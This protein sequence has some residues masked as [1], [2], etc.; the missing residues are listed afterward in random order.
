MTT[1]QRRF[2]RHKAT[3]SYSLRPVLIE[4]HDATGPATEFV[5][6]VVAALGLDLAE[7]SEAEDTNTV[8]YVQVCGSTLYADDKQWNYPEQQAT[9]EYWLVSQC[10]PRVA[11]NTVW[12]TVQTS[13]DHYPLLAAAMAY[14]TTGI[15]ASG[16]LLLDAD[17]SGALTDTILDATDN[18]VEV[19][20]FDLALPSPH[21]YLLNAP[22]WEDVTLL[23]Q[24]HGANP[25]NSVLLDDTVAAARHHFHTVVINCGADLFMAQRLAADGAQV[26]HVDDFSRPLYVQFEPYKKIDYASHRI[27]EYGTRR[28]F[29][30]IYTNTRRRK[31]MRRWMARGDG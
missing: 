4:T 26:V 25:L 1:T 11:H 5:Y 28:D 29:Q 17:A 16:T 31:G 30:F 19:L 3:A 23:L 8:V 2:R 27:P 20:D 9:F 12:A 7:P 24:R 14:A 6:A 22:I 15:A 18:S 13:H 21:I 10:F